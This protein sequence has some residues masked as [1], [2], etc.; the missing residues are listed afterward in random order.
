MHVGTTN[1]RGMIILEAEISSLFPYSV[2]Y[3]SFLFKVGVRWDVNVERDDCLGF[4]L[5]F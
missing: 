1:L 2:L 4:V 3:K 5:Y